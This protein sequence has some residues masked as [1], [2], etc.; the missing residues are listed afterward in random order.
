MYIMVGARLKS[1][2]I[3]HKQVFFKGLILCVLLRPHSTDKPP[4]HWFICFAIG[5]KLVD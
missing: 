4:Y 3:S 1:Y 2:G 5:P